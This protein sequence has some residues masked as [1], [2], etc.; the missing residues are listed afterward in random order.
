MQN[1]TID[2][3]KLSILQAERGMTNKKFAEL[4]GISQVTLFYIKSGRNAT[5]R[6]IGKIAEGLGVG[7]SDIATFK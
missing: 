1:L 3:K 2:I 4:L 5:L 6:T 7:V